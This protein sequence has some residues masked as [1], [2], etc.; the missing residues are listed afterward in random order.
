MASQQGGNVAPAPEVES[1]E[2]SAA[3]GVTIELDAEA[4]AAI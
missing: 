4:A 3:D 2:D 1:A